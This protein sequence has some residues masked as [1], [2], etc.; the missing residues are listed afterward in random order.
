MNSTFASSYELLLSAISELELQEDSFVLH[1]GV[2][3]S[4][5]RK[6]SFRDTILSLLTMQGGSLSTTSHDFFQHRLP[7]DIPSL[8][9]IHQQRAKLLPD[10]MSYL[11]YHFT[12][13]LPAGHTYDGFQLLACDGSDL[14]ICY[15]PA[16]KESCKPSGNG[17]RGSNQLHLHALYDLCNKRYTDIRIEK[18]MVSNESRA[19]VQMLGNI[20]TPARTIILADRGYETYHVFAHIMAK[21]L[22]FV[23]RTKDISR[24]GGISYGFRLPDRELDEDLDFFITRSTVHSK[25]DPV[26]YKKLSP[27]EREAFPPWRIKELYHLRWGIETSFRKLKYS[28]GLSQ[29]HSKKARYVEQE[30]YARVILYNFCESVTPHVSTHQKKTK[31]AYQVNFT[32]AVHICKAFLQKSS[33]TIS[34]HIETL[35]LRY[36]VPV[37]PGRKFP[38]TK[39]RKGFV[40]F[41]YRV[42]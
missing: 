28:L 41:A 26:H 9:A 16:D 11:F 1:P 34:P 40:S 6:I 19:L 30:I 37:K 35:L 38:R 14:N 36:L 2:D 5:K 25:K 27:L 33:P 39:K 42:S 17:K 8:S 32:M 10:A 24:R 7:A 4:K 15:D 3:F 29:L 22:S 18:T 12:Q 13:K 23:I 21:G 20:S 31:Y